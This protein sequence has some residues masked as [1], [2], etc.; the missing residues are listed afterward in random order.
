MKEKA[1]LVFIPSPSIGHLASVI[2]FAKRLL[3]LD[4]DNAA[5]NDNSFS[6]TILVM[7]A[8]A[9]TASDNDA[10]VKSL[11]RAAATAGASIRFI[12]VPQMDPPPLHFF[13]SPEKF[14][15]EYLDSHKD[16]IKEAIIKHVLS[17]NVKIA[18]LVLDVFCSSMIDTANELGVPSY[19]FFTS[20]AAFLGL[21]LH[22]QTRGGEEFEESETDSI[23]IFTYANP[24]PYRVLPSLCFDKH[25][26]FSAFENFG[27]RLKEMKGIIVNT[28]E[29]LESHAVEYLMKCDGVPPVYT[30]G[31]MIDLQGDVQARPGGSGPQR[32]E[33]IRWLDDQP[34]SSVVFLCF[35]SRGCFGEEQIKEIARGLEKSGVRFLWCL[36]KPPPKDKFEMPGEYTCVEEILPRGFQERTKDRGMICGWAPQK[37]VLGHRSIGG[38][39]SH[40]GWNSILESVWFG[41]PM[42]TWPIYAEQQTNAFQMVRDLGLAVEMRLDYRSGTEN[43][44][45]ADELARAVGC[46]MDGDSVVGKRVKEVS[47]KARLA[48]RDGGSSFAAT[49]RLIEDLFGNVS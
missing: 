30:V 3:L 47:V 34:A 8:L 12:G 19:V 48:L 16:C 27:R 24:V 4:R 15:T 44:V 1:E 39:V 33:I 43:H 13:R 45:L 22:L 49:K 28:F 23:D 41:V 46:V 38:F 20:G 35:G 6:I 42:V 37:E 32:D 7:Q 31:P 26:G 21:V 25:G 17:N 18:G 5:G 36:R 2:V 9:A 29:E 40:C 10:R 11:A 14:I